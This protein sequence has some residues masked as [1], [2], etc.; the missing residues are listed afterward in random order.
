VVCTGVQEF[1]RRDHKFKVSLKLHSK[2]LCQPKGCIRMDG[3]GPCQCPAEINGARRRCGCK[4]MR[5]GDEQICFEK[6]TKSQ[7][8]LRAIRPTGRQVPFFPV[9]IQRF[10]LPRY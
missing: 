3:E 1:E 8:F 4:G 7:V 2:T 6:V 5:Q 9:R 10:Q